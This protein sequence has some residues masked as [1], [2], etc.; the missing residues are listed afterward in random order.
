MTITMKQYVQELKFLQKSLFF[1]II[2]FND[3]QRFISIEYLFFSRYRQFD[4]FSFLS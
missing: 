2:F 4:V 3:F 1:E